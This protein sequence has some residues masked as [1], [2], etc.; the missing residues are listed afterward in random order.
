MER[1]VSF[2]FQHERKQAHSA[3]PWENQLKVGIQGP[4]I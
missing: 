3:S 1:E 2:G 4:S